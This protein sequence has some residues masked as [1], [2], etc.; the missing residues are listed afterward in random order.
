MGIAQDNNDN[1]LVKRAQGLL[2][3]LYN[4]RL[5]VDDL[6]FSLRRRRW[7]ANVGNTWRLPIKW[8][9]NFFISITPASWHSGCSSPSE[10]EISWQAKHSFP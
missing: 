9:A 3:Y 6:C 5:P 1:A 10:G 7:I 4:D 8:F 2:A